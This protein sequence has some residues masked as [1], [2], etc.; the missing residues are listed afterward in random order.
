MEIALCANYR[1]LNNKKER[2]NGPWVVVWANERKTLALSIQYNTMNFV[3]TVR[4]C[5]VN[6]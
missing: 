2:N 6:L 4:D 3:S 5:G 1:H